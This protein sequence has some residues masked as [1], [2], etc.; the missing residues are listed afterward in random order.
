MTR[1]HEQVILNVRSEVIGFTQCVSK[2]NQTR[3][4]RVSR[5][6]EQKSTM[7]SYVL[8]PSQSSCSNRC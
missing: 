3:K 1:G 6:D 4:G 5:F 7:T 8:G 2:L